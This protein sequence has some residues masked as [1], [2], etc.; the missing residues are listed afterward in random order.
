MFPNLRKRDISLSAVAGVLAVAAIVA[1]ALPILAQTPEEKG[2][3]IAKRSDASD[4]GFGD[5]DVEMTMVLRNKAGKESRRTL[6]QKTLE[7]Q[8]ENLGD[9]SLIVFDNPADIDGTA[10][11]SHAKILE[12]D[13]QWLF[14][15]A[16]KRTKRI[17]SVNKSG[18]FV[19]SEFAFEDFTALELNKYTYKWLR[20]EACGSMTCDVVE[21]YPRYENSG[22]TKQISWI[23]QTDYQVRQVDFYDRRG[24]LLKTL[25]LVDYRE[26]DGVWRAHTMKMRNHKTGKSTDLTFSDFEFKTGLDENDFVK[27]VLRRAR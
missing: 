25:E 24:D 6:S 10:L 14:L 2:Y 4:R 17:S 11:L 23:D 8:D 7:V 12:P 19:G 26:Y 21:R 20:E 22:Y 16:L 1:T 9:R 13:D 5:S 3:E 18:P 27:D 15:P